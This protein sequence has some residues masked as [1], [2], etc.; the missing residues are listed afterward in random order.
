MKQLIGKITMSEKEE[1]QSLFVR[2]N[3]LME[4]SKAITPQD[5]IYERLITDLNETNVKYQQWWNNMA[6]K[7]KWEGA[8]DCRWQI[9]F[10][11]CEIYLVKK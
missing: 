11:K 1:I 7:Y 8:E 6:R 9:D 3:S 2:K 10:E 5:S 4:L